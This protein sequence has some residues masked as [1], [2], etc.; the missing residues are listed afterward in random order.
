MARGLALGLRL[1]ERT[2]R[3][4]WV[5]VARL[6]EVHRTGAPTAVAVL[7]GRAVLLAPARSGYRAV[8]GG[9]P[10]AALVSSSADGA[11]ASA[12]LQELGY[13]VVR[14]SSS[15]SAVSGLRA[16]RRA[17]TAGRSPVIT[18]DGPRGPAGVV[19]PGIV[20]VAPRE[21]I[22]IIPLASAC[23]RGLR[24]RSWDR[25][26]IPAPFTRVVSL[27]GRPVFLDPASGDREASRIELQ[28]RLR[29]LHRAAERLARR[30]VEVQA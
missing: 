25:L 21:G 28:A 23:R 3:T 12:I 9:R 29:S 17:L 13:E 27:V 2:L 11:W 20:A 16:L 1:L 10:R 26:W 5:G 30:A 6:A 18:V 22:W 15:R 7:H 14:G 4:R 24:L 8:F 19:A